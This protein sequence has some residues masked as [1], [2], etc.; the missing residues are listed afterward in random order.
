[1]SQ[2]LPEL[3]AVVTAEIRPPFVVFGSSLGAIM[4][5]ELVRRLENHGHAAPSRLVVSS[6]RAPHVV[7]RLPEYSA[8]PDAQFVAELAKLGA[9]PCEAARRPDLLET[10]LPVLRAD[11]ELGQTY[12]YRPGPPVHVPIDAVTGSN[13]AYVP[14]TMVSRWGDLT[15]G[16][17]AAIK[18][19]GKHD[20]LLRS[21][22]GLR[23]AV[24]ASCAAAC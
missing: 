24:I 19:Q 6:A 5:F 12:R 13:D 14:D 8:M 18:V 17:F 1:M 22:E 10:V 15:T 16:G 21:S 9:L 7:G 2:V 23:A 11:F 4:A 20:L 3:E